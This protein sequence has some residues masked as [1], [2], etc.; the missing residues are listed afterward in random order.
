[1]HMHTSKNYLSSWVAL[2]EAISLLC[3][4]LVCSKRTCQ[5]T[6]SGGSFHKTSSRKRIYVPDPSGW[7]R[8]GVGRDPTV[9]WVKPLKR[10]K[11]DQT[12]LTQNICCVFA[13]DLLLTAWFDFMLSIET[14]S[15]SLQLLLNTLFK[16][17]SPLVCGHATDWLEELGSNWKRL[18]TRRKQM[19]DFTV[20]KRELGLWRW[21]IWNVRCRHLS[22]D[23]TIFMWQK[24]D[25]KQTVL[26]YLSLC[27]L[28]LSAI[29]ILSSC[30]KHEQLSV[31]STLTL[32]YKKNAYSVKRNK[33]WICVKLNSSHLS[34]LVMPFPS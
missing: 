2:I 13:P 30:I 19:S 4:L 3:W 16:R 20:H 5:E 10:T 18:E 29:S 34:L 12:G 22:M 31:T 25:R 14:I 21:V 27:R 24:Q 32:K 1:M 23:S 15:V 6:H 7:T 26:L 8:G 11:V 9:L 17:C 28:P 33:H